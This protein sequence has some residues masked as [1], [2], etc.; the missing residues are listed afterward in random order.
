MKKTITI[1]VLLAVLLIAGCVQASP[2]TKKFGNT[3]VHFRAD[4]D[5]A[6][7]VPIYPNETVLLKTLN[8]PEVRKI[9]IAFIPNDEENGY[10]AADG[11][12]LSYK[13][14]LAYKA[15]YGETMTISALE[16]NT[17]PSQPPFGEL[18]IW[19]HGPA[20]GANQTAVIVDGGIIDIEGASMNKTD[21]T[22]TDLDL[23]VD[24]LLLSFMWQTD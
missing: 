13:L 19:M 10:Y 6:A 9:N 3:D 18:T 23:A 15:M 20:S 8:D 17:T 14:S 21:R 2:T 16:L 7:Q 12:E 11:Y 4:L 22:Y 24:K 5:K 1:L